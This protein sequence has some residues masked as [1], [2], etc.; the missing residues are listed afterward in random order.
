M[1]SGGARPTLQDLARAAD[2]HVSTASRALSKTSSDLVAPDVVK[3][4]RQLAKRLGYRQVRRRRVVKRRRDG[5]VGVAVPDITDPAFPPII[6]GIEE[7]LA[8]RD[9]VAIL[10]NTD[11]N[12]IRFENV[13][14]MMRTRGV[15]GFILGSVLRNDPV[16]LRLA[17]EVPVVTVTREVSGDKLCSVL[18]DDDEGMRLVLTH[19]ASLGH[20]AIG[21]IAGP[22]SL[23][24][25]YNRYAAFVRH[26]R[27]LD[28]GPRSPIAAFAKVFNESEG[29]R[30]TEELLVAEPQLTAIVC[31]NDRL[32]VGAIAALRRNGL[33]C[34]EDVSVTG[35]NDMPLADRLLPPLTTVRVQHF[36]AGME[37]A[38]IIVDLIE[39]GSDAE[40]RRT[41]LPVELVVRGSTGFAVAEASSA[42]R[43]AR[44]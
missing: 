10:T 41:V 37:A 7:G 28:L 4:I 38:T 29:E 9:Y 5:L 2:V 25:G 36:R 23:S 34:P 24:T 12:A 3:R 40:P 15:E 20:R 32:A 17:A 43:R 33:R 1:K 16:A 31:A 39:D 18:H 21:A 11:G 6:K 42:R 27:L 44:V 30:C 14:A 19:L 26:S 35:Y 8:R 22:Q 13:L